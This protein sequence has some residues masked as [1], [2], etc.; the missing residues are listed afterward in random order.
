MAT[1]TASKHQRLPLSLP[2]HHTLPYWESHSCSVLKSD[3]EIVLRMHECK[4]H[5]KSYYAA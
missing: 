3:L 4:K 1:D 2:L 5:C